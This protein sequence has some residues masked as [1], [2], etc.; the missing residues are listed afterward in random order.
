MQKVEGSSPFIRSSESPAQAGFFV[1]T[2][3]G[4][5]REPPDSQPLVSLAHVTRS[6][7]TRRSRWSTRKRSVPPGRGRRQRRTDFDGRPRFQRCHER[8]S[9]RGTSFHADNSHTDI[10]PHIDIWTTRWFTVGREMTFEQAVAYALQTQIGPRLLG[11]TL[12]TR[13]LAHDYAAAAGSRA[14]VSAICCGSITPAPIR[15][16][17]SARSRRRRSATDSG[18]TGLL[19]R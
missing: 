1:R 15:D 2:G 7:T 5:P 9:R 14:G 19:K 11:V 17:R 10:R 8:A 6:P 12:V 18:G 3:T 16:V 13:L 4:R